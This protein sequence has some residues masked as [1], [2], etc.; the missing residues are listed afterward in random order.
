MTGGA[1]AEVKG[2]STSIKG[3]SADIK[4][5]SA[6]FGRRL[7]AL[8]Y[9]GFLLAALLMTYTGAILIFTRRAVLLETYG[10]WVYLYRA[11]LI[12]VIAAYYVLNWIRSGQTLGMRA[13]HLR[14]VS[15][16][17]STLNAT[18]ALLR[19]LCGFLAWPPA[20]LGV[21]W[22]YVDPDHLAIHDRLSGTRVVRLER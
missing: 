10:A 1:S 12:A 6:G 4:S 11:G 21:L 14:A 5:V 17:G 19:F 3:A 7:A 20:A 9:D 15:D 13:W 22:L 18:S 8:I 2:V 16:A